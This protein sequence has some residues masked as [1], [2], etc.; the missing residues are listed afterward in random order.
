VYKYIIIVSDATPSTKSFPSIQNISLIKLHSN[1]NFNMSHLPSHQYRIYVRSDHLSLGTDSKFRGSVEEYFK[2]YG[3]TEDIHFPRSQPAVCYVS[4]KEEKSMNA[5]LESAVHTIRNVGHHVS[6]ASKRPT[7]NPHEPVGRIHI[8]GITKE[9]ASETILREFF[10]KFGEVRDVC[11]PT[12][13]NNGKPKGFA[14][15]SF[16]KQADCGKVL[17]SLPI[18]IRGVGVDVSQAKPRENRENFSGREN[19]RGNWDGAHTWD[20][21]RN[22]MTGNPHS[23]NNRNRSN[24]FS[25]ATFPPPQFP[26]HFGASGSGSSMSNAASAHPQPGVLGDGWESSTS[27]WMAQ[28][29]AMG[30]DQ[31]TCLAMMANAAALG[32]I[33]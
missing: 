11:V 2:A 6:R 13:G 17:D 12:H 32:T 29:A 22:H 31:A 1:K 25:S 4:F 27:S 26:T 15:V 21:G 18:K 16:T 30:Y 5:V 14:F 9:I 19:P 23:H 8:H 20:P 10:E 28:A 24:S 3:E 7:A 33:F